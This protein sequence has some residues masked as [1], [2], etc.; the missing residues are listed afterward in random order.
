MIR[1]DLKGGDRD[2]RVAIESGVR[3]KAAEHC[4]SPKPAGHC[5]LISRLAFWS[6]AM[7]RRFPWQHE[8][9]AHLS[10]FYLDKTVSVK[11]A[12]HQ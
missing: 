11:G 5:A 4:R 6:A 7:L 8:N 1:S 12:V 10:R 3:S 9:P 2:D